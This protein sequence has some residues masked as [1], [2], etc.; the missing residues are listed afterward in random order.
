MAKKIG[1]KN[2]LFVGIGPY[3]AICV[4]AV[5]LKTYND[6]LLLA[7]LIGTAQGGVQSLSRS[8]FGQLIPANRANEF[9]GF[10]N[11]FGKFSSILGTTLLGITAQMTGNSL[12]GVF[13]LIALFII[14]TVLL[15]FVKIPDK[16]GL[17]NE[18]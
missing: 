8:L 18:G 3:I 14:G 4:M 10:Y 6:F 13:S 1:N 15:L 11:I 9:F 2:T 12:D 7:I 17:E 5:G 16:K